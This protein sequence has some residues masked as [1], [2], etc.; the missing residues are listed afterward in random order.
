MTDGKFVQKL[1]T[2]GAFT[3][4]CAKEKQLHR[5]FVLTKSQRAIYKKIAQ[6]KLSLQ[7]N[8]KQ[9]IVVTYNIV[10]KNITIHNRKINK[11]EGG[12]CSFEIESCIITEY[13]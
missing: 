1:A 7:N 5:Q 11:L 4:S 13:N 8:F 6:L 2:S 3:N 9:N 10:E 12:G